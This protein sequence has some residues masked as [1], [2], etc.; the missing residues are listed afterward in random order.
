MLRDKSKVIINVVL[1]DRNCLLATG[2]DCPPDCNDVFLLMYQSPGSY[3]ILCGF[4]SPVVKI[5]C[6]LLEEFYETHHIREANQCR[7]QCTMFKIFNKSLFANLP[8]KIF[9]F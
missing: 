5:F 1:T 3:G 4:G 9:V 2:I 7:E 8:V 6:A